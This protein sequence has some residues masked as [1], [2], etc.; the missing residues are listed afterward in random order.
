MLQAEKGQI[1]SAV[2]DNRPTEVLHLLL[3][4]EPKP[5]AGH[6]EEETAE[7]KDWSQLGTF[8]LQVFLLLT[9]FGVMQLTKNPLRRQQ[10]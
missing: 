9:N 8:L 4:L 6:P 3:F 1:Y 5:K 2:I 10:S 7:N